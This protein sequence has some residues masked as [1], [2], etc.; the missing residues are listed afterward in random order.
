VAPNLSASQTEQVGREGGQEIAV[1]VC[2][3]L[4]SVSFYQNTHAVAESSVFSGRGPLTRRHLLQAS[5]ELI[6]LAVNQILSARL[7]GSQT[8]RIGREVRLG[9]LDA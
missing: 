4:R 1:V 8:A 5:I 6:A 9:S 7:R 3:I 2:L